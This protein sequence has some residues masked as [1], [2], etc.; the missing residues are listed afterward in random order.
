MAEQNETFVER[1]RRI[2]AE[3]ASLRNR[4]RKRPRLKPEPRTIMVVHGDG[5]VTRSRVPDQRLRF[6]FPLRAVLTAS[7]LVVM[8][9]G[10]VIWAVGEDTY[11]GYIEGLMLRSEISQAAGY[12]LA[13]DEM[14]MW[15]VAGYDLLATEF[16][17]ILGY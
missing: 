17:R 16:M 12:I 6:G 1:L 8:V 4:L 2:E 10:F 13:P 11:S 7:L 14:S 5:I 9:K 15:L 3:E